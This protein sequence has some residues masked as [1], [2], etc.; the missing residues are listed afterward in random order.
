MLRQ[1]VFRRRRLAADKPLP[2]PIRR[3][4]R[5]VRRGERHPRK[6]RL[7]AEALHEGLGGIPK[8]FR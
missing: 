7:V 1:E 3:L 6:E 8:E 2:K 4:P 5:I